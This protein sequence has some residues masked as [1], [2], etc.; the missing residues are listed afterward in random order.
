MVVGL[1]I[2]SVSL[3]MGLI[4]TISNLIGYTDK[5]ERR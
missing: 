2:A 3:L 1:I 4:M 5:R